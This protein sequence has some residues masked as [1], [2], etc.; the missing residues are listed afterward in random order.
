M[1]EKLNSVMRNFLDKV[2]DRAIDDSNN[3]GYLITKWRITM[4]I[5]N[6]D[7]M[8]M[9]KISLTATPYSEFLKHHHIVE[10]NDYLTLEPGDYITDGQ[11]E[12]EASIIEIS[13]RIVAREITIDHSFMDTENVRLGLKMRSK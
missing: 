11:R 5:T 7:Y 10:M 9:S 13:S 6:N 2:N 1:N 12:F 4:N 8:G 3:T